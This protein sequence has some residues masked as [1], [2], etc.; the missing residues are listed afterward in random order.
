VGEGRLLHLESI[1]CSTCL[2]TGYRLQVRRH[3]NHLIRLVWFGVLILTKLVVCF[4]CCQTNLHQCS[5]HQLKKGRPAPLSW[6]KGRR[7]P[8]KKNLENDPSKLFYPPLNASKWLHM[9]KNKKTARVDDPSDLITRVDCFWAIESSR[10]QVEGLSARR[11]STSVDQVTWVIHEGGFLFIIHHNC[12]KSSP[13]RW[14]VSWNTHGIS[15]IFI[16]W[17]IRLA[18]GWI[19]LQYI[20][21]YFAKI[22]ADFAT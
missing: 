15:N 8:F 19:S 2:Y 5:P 6:Q 7:R 14:L 20:H 10:P 21:H 13:I 3:G 22:K 1:W 17:R 12:Q 18:V 16:T 4:L 9:P 11:Q